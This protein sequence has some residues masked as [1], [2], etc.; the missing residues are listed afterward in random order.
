MSCSV[1]KP[2]TLAGTPEP[3]AQVVNDDTKL[4]FEW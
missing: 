3:P 1:N 4:Q 2:E